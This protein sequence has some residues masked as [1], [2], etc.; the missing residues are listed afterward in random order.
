MAGGRTF[1][2]RLL[3]DSK[4]VEAAF[5]KT[6]AKMAAFAAKSAVASAAIGAVFR[7][8]KAAADEALRFEKTLMNLTTQIGLSQE[9]ADDIGAS[10]LGMSDL[11]VGPQQLAE[12]YYFVASA[13]L[14]GAAAMEV[15]Q[16]SA[17]AAA[18]GMGETETVA[19][20]LTSVLNAYGTE[21]I[22][23]ADATDTLLKAVRDGKAEAADMAATMGQ[24]IPIAASMGL[25]FEDVSASMAALTR[26]GVSAAEST[27]QLRSFLVGLL[28]PSK[29]AEEALAKY[30]LTSAGLRADLAGPGG[31][32]SVLT[33]IEDA[34]GGSS[35][36]FAEITGRVEALSFLNTMLGDSM[37]ANIALFE[38]SAEAAG[39]TD[40]AFAE[41]SRSTAGQLDALKS[42]FE[43]TKIL[44]GDGS[45]AVDVYG[46]S[47][48]A[49]E[50]ILFRLNGV[51]RDGAED[52]AV[53]TRMRREAA[54]AL[55]RNRR[56]L[57][58]VTGAQREAIMQ[59]EEYRSNLYTLN[60]A[61]Q[62]V[63]LS[64]EDSRQALLDL[65]D[66]RKE[67]ADV[68]NDLT[69]E[70]LGYLGAEKG[71]TASADRWDALARS[72][73]Y[74]ADESGNLRTQQELL[75]EA[76]WGNVSA[77]EQQL[78]AQM[79][80]VNPQLNAIRAQEDLEKATAQ[81]EESLTDTTLSERDRE[82]ALLEL[83][84]AQLEADA[85]NDIAGTTLNEFVNGPLRRALEA[86][87]LQKDEIDE[88]IESTGNY[89]EA[90]EDLNG[91]RVV[92]S[93]VE[94]RET[95]IVNPGQPEN[96]LAKGG[97]V[98][99]PLYPTLI[100]EAGPEAVIPLERLPSLFNLDE[101]SG[102]TIEPGAIQV[103]VTV[104][105]DAKPRDVGLAVDRSMN[106][107]IARL[108]RELAVA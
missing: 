84:A 32:S 10:L 59:S 55:D 75:S 14:E 79:R 13:G 34:T 8:F 107:A 17:K 74:T 19:D 29:E 31:L 62:L 72:Y 95:I 106:D 28:Q 1:L 66:I 12:A 108:A 22:N 42:Q 3:G 57:E 4:G 67:G 99:G 53:A 35:A 97:I 60:R 81:Y 88:L 70:L 104:S 101:G 92:T 91:T 11:L 18:I 7:G 71:L 46:A 89:K 49:L 64:D 80:L 69:R 73:G 15:V 85:A 5:G 83:V 38:E 41:Y 33:Q 21:N 87:G 102:V 76:M 48:S 100:G 56:M 82:K 36:A 65:R 54:E 86:Y 58:G 63:R 93:I 37:E 44:L 94:R 20:L 103:S 30:G 50:T 40:Q 61:Q 27:T 24:V 23:A 6:S 90:L 43:T 96:A 25:R 9:A 51:L 16:S 68:T 47:A 105:G 45:G 98:T 2:I 77:L 26:A 39:I 78:D 52:E